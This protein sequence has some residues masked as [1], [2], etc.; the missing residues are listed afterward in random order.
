[1]I[2]YVES[3]KEARKNRKLISDYSKVVKYKVNIKKATCIPA[4]NNW[5]LKLE[6][7]IIKL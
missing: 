2:V 6:T 5:N 1:M 7:K 4:I 3:P